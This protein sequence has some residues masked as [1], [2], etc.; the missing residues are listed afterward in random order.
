M[1][2]ILTG[3]G[4]RAEPQTVAAERSVWSVIL[5]AADDAAPLAA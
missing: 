5:Q 2:R 4:L 1:S 3:A